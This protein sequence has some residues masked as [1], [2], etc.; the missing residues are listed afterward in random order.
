[1]KY[2]L[3]YSKLIVLINIFTILIKI[4]VEI[5]CVVSI[6]KMQN[7]NVSNISNCLKALSLKGMFKYDPKRNIKTKGSS[8]RNLSG[9]DIKF[10]NTETMSNFS[11]SYN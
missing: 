10:Y 1:M 8:F 7:V 9:E 4:F 2:Y 11:S 5:K 6:E 3:V